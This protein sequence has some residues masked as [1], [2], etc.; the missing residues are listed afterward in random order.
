MRYLNVELQSVGAA[1]ERADG[2]PS[3]DGLEC[4][5]HCSR[6]TF[7]QSAVRWLCRVG[8]DVVMLGPSAG[9]GMSFGSD[10]G[11]DG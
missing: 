9:R 7:M 11:T 8:C 4:S 1:G 5:Q 6:V 10:T 3:S 2:H